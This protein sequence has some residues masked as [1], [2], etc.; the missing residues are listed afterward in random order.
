M[1][2]KSSPLPG[3]A[4]QPLHLFLLLDCSGSMSADGKIQALNAAVKEALPH[5]DSVNE[6]NPHARLLVRVIEFSTDARWHVAEPTPVPE[7]RWKNVSAGGFTDLGSALDLLIPE[8]EKM[9][10]NAL[11]PA[12]ILVSDGMPTDDYEP[13]LRAL[14]AAEGGRESMRAAVAIGRDADRRTLSAFM[15][16]GVEPL[17]AS[18]PEQLAG[19]IRWATTRATVLASTLADMEELKSEFGPL[20]ADEKDGDLVW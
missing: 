5:L 19:A 16:G 7:L 3:L 15:G 8:L 11:P 1:A 12:I 9:E 14:L 6:A 10:P 18:N 17:S 20:L 2:K 13:S 4:Q